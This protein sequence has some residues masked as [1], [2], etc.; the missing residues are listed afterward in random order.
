MLSGSLYHP[1]LYVV[2]DDGDPGLRVWAASSLIEDRSDQ[3]PSYPQFLQQ[4]R[5]KVIL[6]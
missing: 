6:P 2:K 5:D 4:I 3:N 1:H